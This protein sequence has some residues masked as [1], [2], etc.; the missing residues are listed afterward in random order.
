VNTLAPD[1]PFVT[2]DGKERKLHADD[3]MI[4]NAQQQAMCIAG[5]F[6]GLNSGVTE[7]TTRIFLES[8]FF[9]AK[10]IR[11]T[12]FRHL[13]RTDAAQRF[14]KTTDI[15]LTVRTAKGKSFIAIVSWG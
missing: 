5:V 2:L 9:D 15:N 8:A 11:K 12:S 3:L 14:E 13:L 7:Q 4:C 6:G 10:Y 1:T